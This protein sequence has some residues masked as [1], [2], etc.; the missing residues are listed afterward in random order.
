MN[1]IQRV[2]LLTVSC[3][4]IISAAKAED[5]RTTTTTTSEPSQYSTPQPYDTSSSTTSD[6]NA[7]LYPMIY[8]PQTQF[9]VL[10]GD[11]AKVNYIAQCSVD[12]ADL[13]CSVQIVHLGAVASTLEEYSLLNQVQGQFRYLYAGR[14]VFMITKGRNWDASLKDGTT[15]AYLVTVTE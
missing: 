5:T 9:T 2:L 6:P 1:R 11:T 15:K 8:F 14:Y 13:D 3:A 7:T 10:P 4:W 12:D